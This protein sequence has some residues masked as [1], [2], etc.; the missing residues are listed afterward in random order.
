[1]FMFRILTKVPIIKIELSNLTA[2]DWNLI[3]KYWKIT[4]GQSVG[5]KMVKSYHILITTNLNVILYLVDTG[6]L[7]GVQQRDKN[8]AS[9]QCCYRVP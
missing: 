9:N 1:M 6:Q 5:D 3:S 2:R 7:E 4:V 8:R